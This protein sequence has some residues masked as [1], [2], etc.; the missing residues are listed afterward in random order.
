[1]FGNLR[2]VTVYIDNVII[3]SK[4][5]EDPVAHI[6]IVCERIR[7]ASLKF[8]LK[9]CCFAVSVVKVLGHVVT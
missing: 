1:M 2:F 4:L 9:K 3:C 8:K 5:L 6:T 7:Q